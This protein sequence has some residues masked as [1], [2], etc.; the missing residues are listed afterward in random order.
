[1][2]WIMLPAVFT[3]DVG[4]KPTLSSPCVARATFSLF[5]TLEQRFGLPFFVT[6]K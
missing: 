3:L 2:G 4:G 6:P 1:V 5:L